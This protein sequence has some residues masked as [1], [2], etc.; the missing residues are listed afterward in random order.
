MA[1][2]TGV[3]TTLEV[4]NQFQQVYNSTDPLLVRFNNTLP[5]KKFVVEYVGRLNCMQLKNISSNYIP[6]N[7][8]TDFVLAASSWSAASVSI[9]I[10]GQK[11]DGQQYR[12]QLD[13]NWITELEADIAIKVHNEGI[14]PAAEHITNG[15]KRGNDTKAIRHTKWDEFDI[16]LF[17]T[18]K[19]VEMTVLEKGIM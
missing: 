2:V 16:I 8:V 10:R 18:G 6:P 14:T 17:T 11:Q 3:L 9:E 12:I 7:S 15:E 19:L 1:I 5:E 4:L 13:Y